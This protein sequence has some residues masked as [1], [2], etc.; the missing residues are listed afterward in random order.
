MIPIRHGG[1]RIWSRHSMAPPSIPA[2]LETTMAFLVRH[3]DI[4]VAFPGAAILSAGVNGEGHLLT[5]CSSALRGTK[6][7]HIAKTF[8]REEHPTVDEIP[9]LFDQLELS[10]VLGER[11]QYTLST[12][13][14]RRHFHW[15]LLDSPFASAALLCHLRFVEAF[16]VVPTDI[17][18]PKSKY[19]Q[20]N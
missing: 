8:L 17:S 6:T 9:V 11:G 5:V 19:V 1:I 14:P 16:A 4:F 10:R 18:P 3:L 15:S 13:V 7:L 20:Y 12:L 2:S